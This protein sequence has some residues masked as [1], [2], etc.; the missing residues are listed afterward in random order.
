MGSFTVCL[1]M[2]SWQLWTSQRK[3][4]TVPKRL[5]T[6]WWWLMSGLSREREN[7]ATRN[8]ARP[9]ASLK[10][11]HHVVHFFW[12]HAFCASFAR[13][14]LCFNVQPILEFSYLC[15]RVFR[16]DVNG[17]IKEAFPWSQNKTECVN[18][19]LFWSILS[20][21]RDTE[22]FQSIEKPAN[23]STKPVLQGILK[24]GQRYLFDEQMC[25]TL[26]SL[27]RI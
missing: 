1:K 16:P 8:L 13:A 2:I 25:S 3:Y 18:T 22:V 12:A 27:T 26:L 4:R 14:V 7:S 15:F 11:Q 5:P 24:H 19:L 6:P 17:G 23:R 21:A 10:S 20:L 9:V